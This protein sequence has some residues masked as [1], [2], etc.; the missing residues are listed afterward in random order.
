VR[1]WSGGWA[2]YGDSWVA[3]DVIG[4][5]IDLDAHT[6]SFVRNG[7][8]MGVAFENINAGQGVAYFPAVSL[9]RGDRC[10]LNFGRTPFQFP[11][12]GYHALQVPPNEA[13]ARGRYAM[14]A[15]QRLLQLTDQAM[16]TLAA[17]ATVFPTFFYIQKLFTRGNKLFYIHSGGGGVCW[18]AAAAEAAEPSGSV[19]G[20]P[21]AGAG[22]VGDRA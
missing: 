5:C 7:V 19:L 22:S 8:D 14:T 2:P 17:A 21:G 18:D 13:V 6:V 11:R 3:G 10:R 20:Q 4:C 9:S 16:R 1:K 15:M 12:A